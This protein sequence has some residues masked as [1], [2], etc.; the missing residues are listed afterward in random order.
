MSLLDKDKRVCVEVEK[1]RPDL[2]EYNFVVLRG[3][4]EVV[5]YSDERAKVIHRIAEEGKRKLS[6]NF[7]AAHGFKKEEGW[8]S[9]SPER[10]VVL[11]KLKE[12]VE[13]IGLKSPK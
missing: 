11:V 1:Y 5:N 10:P 4:L 3:E 6:T 8:D 7:L 12:V 9:F 2:S 13:K